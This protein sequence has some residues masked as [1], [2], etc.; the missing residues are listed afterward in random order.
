ME[1]GFSMTHGALVRTDPGG[2]RHVTFRACTPSLD[3][4]GTIIKPGG[5]KTEDFDR[6]PLFLWAHDG[7]G[8]LQPPS[9]ESV[10]GRIVE[11]RKSEGSFDIDV[12]FLDE[13]INPKAEMALR[14]VRAGVLNTVSIGFRVLQWHV[15]SMDVRGGPKEVKIFD[16]VDLLEVSLVAIPSN[17]H[18][19]ALVRTMARAMDEQLAYDGVP[20]PAPPPQ[21]ADFGAEAVA[22]IVREWAAGTAIRHGL[23]TAR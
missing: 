23:G 2:S 19:V 21:G 20:P 5:I 16:E 15:E 6:N 1:L 11:H 22:R 12:A 9:I 10:I 17:P 13:S 14:M 4:H 3:R 18:A 8:G 7:Y